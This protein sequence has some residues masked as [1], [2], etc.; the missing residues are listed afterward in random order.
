M[1]QEFTIL[2]PEMAYKSYTVNAD[3]IYEALG[4]AQ[5]ESTYS[6]RLTTHIGF[7]PPTKMPWKV[8]LDGEMVPF[9]STED[10]GGS[11]WH[12]WGM[13]GN[14]GMPYEEPKEE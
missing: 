10:E 9:G 3:N 2:V 1:A 12:V 6:L 11:Y 14:P 5:S 7:V 8:L 13:G 4:K